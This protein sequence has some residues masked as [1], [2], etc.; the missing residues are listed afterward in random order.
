MM[1]S[2]AFVATSVSA[3]VNVRPCEIVAPI[4]RRKLAD[5]EHAEQTIGLVAAGEIHALA[6]KRPQ[7]LERP[8]EPAPVQIVLVR[9]ALPA[10][11]AL[12]AV[13]DDEPVG[14]GIGKRANQNG[15]DDREDRGVRADTERERERGDGGERRTPEKRANGESQ[16]LTQDVHVVSRL[17]GDRRCCCRRRARATRAVRTPRD[18]RAGARR[19]AQTANEPRARARRTRCRAKSIISSVNRSRNEGGKI[20][21]AAR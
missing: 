11:R 10:L 12:H 14:V 1:A 3:S 15:V 21:S 18:R 2:G 7:F 6:A 4:T 5:D 19:C 9:H 13:H 16:I 17:V 20:S 8:I